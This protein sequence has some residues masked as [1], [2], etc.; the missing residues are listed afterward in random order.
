VYIVAVVDCLRLQIINK[1][2]KE[3]SVLSGPVTLVI[4]SVDCKITLV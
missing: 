1:E 3:I 2:G 4:G